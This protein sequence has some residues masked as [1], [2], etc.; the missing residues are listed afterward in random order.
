MGEKRP[1]ETVLERPAPPGA[2]PGRPRS[3][4]TE[5]VGPPE[6]VD[7]AGD[8]GTAPLTRDVPRQIAQYHILSVLGEGGMGVV[9]HAQQ[10]QPVRRQVAL[11]VMRT[12][13]Q[14]RTAE[15]RFDAER[16]A[17]ARLSHPNVAQMFEA[18][19]TRD[20][21]PFFA[22]ELVR[23]RSITC[24]CDEH[25]LVIR[26]RLELFRAVCDGVQHAH[27]KGIVH[28]DLKPS[29]LLVTE[30][31]GRPV[32]KIIDF[33]IAKAIGEPLVDGT[34]LTGDRAIGTPVY[35][36]PEALDGGLDL[37]TR[38]DVYSLGVVLYELLIGARP[39]EDDSVMRILRRIDDGTPSPPSTRWRHLD[40]KARREAARRRGLEEAVFERRLR[41]DLDWIVMRAIARDREERYGSPAELAAD[42]GRH[43]SHEP[44]EARPPSAMYR[45]GK[46]VR[47]RRGVVAATLVVMMSLTW[48]IV[49]RTL[50]ARRTAREARVAEEVSAFLVGLFQVS[51]PSEARGN[52]ITAREILDK[53]ARRIERE[54]VGQPLVQARLMDTMGTVYRHLGLYQPATPLLEGAL[55]LRRR[56]LADE[57]PDV[58]ESLS[59]L[60]SL[61]RSK[62]EYDRAEALAREALAMRRRLLGDE[63]FEVAK[64]LNNLAVIL[65][66]KG[67]YAGAEPLYREALAMFRRLRGGEDPE[68]ARCMN[69]LASLLHHTGDYAGAEALYR[70]SLALRRR[71]LGDE[72]PD[73][74]LSVNNLASL[75]HAKG[76]LDG[77]ANLYREALEMW[78]RMVGDEHPD[79]ARTLSNLAMVLKAKGDYAAAEPLYRESLAMRRRLLGNEHPDV[80]AGLNN[81][82]VLL[83]AMGDYDGAEPLFRE[84]LEIHRRLLG[85]EHPEIARSLCNLGMLLKV[86]GDY[87][88]AEPLFDEALAIRRRLFGAEHPMVALSLNALG[89]LLYEK[90]DYEGAE[91]NLLEALAMRRRVLGE[92][93]LDVAE[94]LNNLA[95]LAM[96][97]GELDRAEA[98]NRD[99]L[100]TWKRALGD[101]HPNVALGLNNLGDVARARGDNEGAEQLYRESLAMRRRL[102]GDE[103]VDVAESLKSLA[104][105]NLARGRHEEAERMARESVAVYSHALPAGHW[106]IAVAQG[107]LG[108]CLTGLGR[109]AEAEDV[110]LASYPVLLERRGEMSNDTQAVRKQLM[111][112]YR[113]WG[114]PD[115]AAEY[116][117]QRAAMGGRGRR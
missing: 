107:V 99:A 106:R 100:T 112:L 101:E 25:E 77:A 10:S 66:T 51:D 85:D 80:A 116:L 96:A 94:S 68:V 75:L 61:L 22:M 98:L 95:L 3:G 20:G 34:L 86:R 117:D 47:R 15:L 4:A 45:V 27:H 63:H 19:T 39:V 65:K 9:Y 16:Q 89:L 29:N 110:L 18:G 73:V 26:Q 12:V 28:R 67:D 57:H 58:A 13:L 6:A 82:A 42:I 72:H 83:H 35:M 60:A 40:D 44:V 7:R 71:L 55:E 64:N 52:T 37:D 59:S 115:Q 74:A 84:A 43:L 32:P 87:A 8:G 50:E 46:F 30:I 21:Y 14:G 103:H 49:A 97:R 111:T 114:R 104:V 56:E 70:E 93:H 48:G 108:A 102:L 2:D 24:Y 109:F 23:G 17:L 53:G 79:V 113:A 31:D 90:G 41:G 1:P 78:R 36:S 76:D 5:T 11:K 54:L 105:V 69:N 92:D 88:G 81:L 38:A 62:G 33:G 91:A